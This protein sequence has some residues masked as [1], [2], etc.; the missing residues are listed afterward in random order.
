MDRRTF[1]LSSTAVNSV[2][3][4]WLGRLLENTAV[5]DYLHAHQPDLLREFE[6]ILDIASLEQ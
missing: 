3:V 5:F 1:R 6:A 4:N 2:A